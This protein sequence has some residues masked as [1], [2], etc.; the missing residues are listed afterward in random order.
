MNILLPSVCVASLAM[1]GLHAQSPP[2]VS[3]VELIDLNQARQENVVSMDRETALA[4]LSE[5]LQNS[6]DVQVQ[7]T[8]LNGILLGLEGQRGID[9]PPG[10]GEL[11]SRLLASSD[12]TLRERALQLSQAFGDEQAIRKALSILKDTSADVASRRSAMASLVTQRRMEMLPILEDLIDHQELQVDAIRAFTSIESKRAP[13]LMLE[14]YADFDE[15]TQRAVIETLATRKPYAEALQEALEAGIVPRADLPAYVAR[16]MGE[17]LGETFTATYG[18]QPLSE[19]KEAMIGAYKA[20]ATAGAMAGADASA[21]RVVY[22]RICMSCHV[23][24]GEGGKVGPELT[25]SNRADLNYLLLNVLYPNDDI[26]DAYKM[27]MITTKDGQ[28]L[29]GSITEEDSQRV[30]LNMVGQK[31]IVPKAD[32]KARQMHDISMMPAG[33]LQSLPEKEVLDF[34]KYMQTKEQVDLPQ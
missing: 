11:N 7:A 18:V 20:M 29:A 27:V 32:V 17:M 5:T 2:P 23:L 30:V 24:Y 1:V 4:I 13:K 8:L 14:G 6:A 31:M 26:A 22:E 28:T 34:F 3:P 21:G 19:D 10:W 25:G 12:A 33:L 15:P 9:P 16:T